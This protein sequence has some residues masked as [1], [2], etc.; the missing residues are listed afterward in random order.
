M[1]IYSN[2]CTFFL[3]QQSPRLLPSACRKRSLTCRFSRFGIAQV[4]LALL[5][6][7]RKRSTFPLSFLYLGRSPISPR[8]KDTIIF[9]KTYC[10]VRFF[11]HRTVLRLLRPESPDE[12][13]FMPLSIPSVPALFRRPPNLRIYRPTLH[14]SGI[15]HYL[16]PESAKDR[17]RQDPTDGSRRRIL[18][19]KDWF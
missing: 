2:S 11:R 7:Y 3:P 10:R 6:A 12:L 13:P 15:N 9:L 14:R 17:Q 18:F 16:C 1:L 8:N 4:N 19:A 5:S